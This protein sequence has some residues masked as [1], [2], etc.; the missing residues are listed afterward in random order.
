LAH[1]A[2]IGLWHLGCV[3]S[4]ALAQ[5]GHTVT[6]TD[7]DVAV[8]R[9]LREGRPPIYEP[10]LSEL[11]AQQAAQG[12]LSFVVSCPDALAGAEYAFITFDTPVDEND[13]SDLAPIETA[14]DMVA[15]HGRGELQTVVMSQVPVGTCQRLAER[16]RKRA[17]HLSVSLVYQPENL[18][19]GEALKAFLA[20]DLIVV[21]AE[22]EAAASRLLRLYE[23]IEG[24]RVTMSW[25]SAEMVKHALN[26]FLATSVSFVN[27]LADLAET[28]GADVRDVVRALR[29]DRRIGAH[30]FLSP[31][32]GFSGGTLA[33]DVQ[34]LRRLGERVGRPTRQLDATLAVNARRLPNIV[35]KIHHL[36]GKPKG[37]QV[38]LLGL[39]YKPGTNTLRRSN[40]LAL[41]RLLMRGGSEVQAFDPQVP[42]PADGT[43]GIMLCSDPYQAAKGA[44][45]IVI[46]TPWPEFKKLDLARLR[47]V[48]RRPVVIDVHNFLNDA[49][50]RNAGLRYVGTGIGDE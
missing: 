29:L 30:A 45:A 19:L 39:T 14:L 8:V 35:D 26:A 46:M 9:G 18:R 5:L 31:G 16:L 44:D 1:V 50:A 38:G 24:A 2:V 3:V 42:K 23:G 28:A 22:N 17:P 13:E 48:M 6:G 33:R 21:G 40:A 7:F 43:Q 34:T 47:S 20:P 12:R 27:E 25:E 36:C 10:G 32:P 15:D 4:S 37:L 49:E 11:L 41:A